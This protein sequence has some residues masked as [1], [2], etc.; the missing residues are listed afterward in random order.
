LDRLILRGWDYHHYGPTRTNNNSTKS[1]PKE[2]ALARGEAQFSGSRIDFGSEVSGLA[3]GIG[4]F[5]QVKNV[6]FFANANP[7][8]VPTVGAFI[9]VQAAAIVLCYFVNNLTVAITFSLD[10]QLQR[11]EY[12]ALFKRFPD[13][14][15]SELW[16]RIVASIGYWIVQY[17]NM[18]FFYS[19]FALLGTV[20][21][22]NDISLWR[23][24]FGNPKDAYSLRNFWG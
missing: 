2:K 8:F 11:S 1:S 4:R 14:T 17:C 16:A 15:L 23:P 7:A 5:W 6:P 18:Q 13:I 19:L 22:P 3:R 9:L 12:I 24:L 21:S 10:P 20:F